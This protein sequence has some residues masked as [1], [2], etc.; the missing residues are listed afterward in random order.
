M[1]GNIG[2]KLKLAAWFVLIFGSLS[3]LGI[4]ALLGLAEAE[5][6][7]AALM[8]FLCAAGGVLLSVV[9]SWI[10]YAL[11]EISE[12]QNKNSSILQE[13]SELLHESNVHLIQLLQITKQIAAP[14]RHGVVC[15]R[16]GNLS[17]GATVKC[18]HCGYD[19]R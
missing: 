16:C 12:L 15:A 7:T 14:P 4:G 1:F 2:G 17:D 5:A 9:L 3:A 18:P 6:M 13:N 19:G 10:I 11:A 8:F